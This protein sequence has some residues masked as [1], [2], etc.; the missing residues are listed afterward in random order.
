M[1]KRE[2]WQKNAYSLNLES[3]K[4]DETLNYFLEGIKHN[5]LINERFKIK[6]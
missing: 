4:T 1:H 3:K 6:L 2:I 5:D